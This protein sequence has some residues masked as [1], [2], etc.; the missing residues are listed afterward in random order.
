MLQYRSSH[1]TRCEMTVVH[2]Y[3]HHDLQWCNPESPLRGSVL[4]Y[5]TNL[6]I[7]CQQSVERFE[8]VRKNGGSQGPVNHGCG[9]IS[10]LPEGVLVAFSHVRPFVPIVMW[11]ILPLRR[12]IELSLFAV[13][14]LSP[15]VLLLRSDSP[16]RTLFKCYHRVT[17]NH[18]LK[19]ELDDV[20]FN[21]NR[22][23]ELIL[24]SVATMNLDGSLIWNTAC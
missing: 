6:M 20:I 9:R 14:P 7:K 21:C 17:Q 22:I 5:F 8:T 3:F 10:W 2:F 4:K 19:V 12:L 23:F 24:V 18:A 16:S 11:F 1:Q 15:R 13:W